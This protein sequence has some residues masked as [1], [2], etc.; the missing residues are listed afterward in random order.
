MRYLLNTVIGFA[1]LAAVLAAVGMMLPRGVTVERSIVID[2]KAEEIFPL[3]NSMQRTEEWSPWLELDPDV[4]L[5]Y[6]GPEEGVGN[7]LIWASDHPNVGRGRQEIVASQEA[8][9]VRM[10]LDFGDMGLAEARFSLEGLGGGTKVTWA[11]ETEM[12]K[13]PIGGWIGLMM[14]RWVGADYERGLANLKKVV[15]D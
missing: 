4:K 12:G 7:V 9:E 11:L 10:E 13:G 6:E 8:S 3:V 1:I 15:E 14:D 5:T 2:A